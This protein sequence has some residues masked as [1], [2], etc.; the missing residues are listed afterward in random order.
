MVF[1]LRPPYGGGG[2]QMIE[3]L[4]YIVLFVGVAASWIG[5][6]IIGG[7]VLAAAGVLAHDGQLDVWLV[8]VAAA[9][10]AWTGGYVGYLV[11]ARAGDALGSLPGRRQRQRRRVLAAGERFYR[12]WG[13]LAVF[14]TPTWVAGALHMRR[15]SFLIWNAL[16]AVVSSLVAVFGAY[17][18][19]GA[20][21]AELSDRR[22][23]VAMAAALTAAAVA[24]AAI[25]RRRARRIAE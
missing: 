20:L 19:A 13:P 12:R 6:P 23:V 14:V 10:G 8:L 1:C 24:G 5:I 25:Y 21:L 3:L 7:A 9:A 22:G 15:N 4:R 17:A 2:M 11:G 18:I 16:A